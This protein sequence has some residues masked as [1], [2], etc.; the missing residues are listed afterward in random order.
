MELECWQKIRQANAEVDVAYQH[1]LDN[2]G[3]QEAKEMY[4][5]KQKSVTELLS[6]M[7]AAV[8]TN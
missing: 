5:E 2:P 8:D 6:D 7:T 3:S 4:L 1:L